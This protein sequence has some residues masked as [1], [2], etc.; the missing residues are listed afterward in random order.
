MVA[1][2][3]GENWILI[4]LEEA[5]IEDSSYFQFGSSTCIT[6]ATGT[7]EVINGFTYGEIFIGF[8]LLI[9]CMFGIFNFIF[10]NFIRKLR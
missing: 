4:P 5:G 2:I 10:K 3:E 6:E 7:P 8:F 1:H 9:F